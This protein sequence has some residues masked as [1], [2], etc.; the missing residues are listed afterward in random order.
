[1]S[2]GAIQPKSRH[3]GLPSTLGEGVY[4]MAQL[5][6][7]GVAWLLLTACG[8][9][10]SP[11]V[12]MDDDWALENTTTLT[13]SSSARLLPPLTASEAAEAERLHQ[14]LIC[15]KDEFEGIT[16]YSPPGRGWSQN[17][18]AIYLY[19]GSKGSELWLRLNIRYF[20]DDWLF[21]H[22]YRIKVDHAE[23]TTLRPSQ[24]IDHDNHSGSVWETLDEPAIS[25]AHVLN[26]IIASQTTCIRMVGKEG[27]TDFELSPKHIQQMRD[28]LLVF[29]LLGGKWPAN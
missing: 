18:N 23:P 26:S 15:K 8:A 21:I 19:I 13:S 11:S 3:G 1:M 25:H 20:G 22:H 27:T 12:G 9:D 2:V 17:K 5:T 7:L 6:A 14:T 29:R 4:L 10:A 24:P 16:W 28:V